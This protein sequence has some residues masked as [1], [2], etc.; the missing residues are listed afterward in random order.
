MVLETMPTSGSRLARDG[1]ITRLF[2][3]E[4]RQP[5]PVARARP[6]R[7]GSL[8]RHIPRFVVSLP[9][10]SDRSAPDLDGDSAQEP[11]GALRID[12]GGGVGAGLP[13]ALLRRPERWRCAGAVAVQVRERRSRVGD[14]S[15]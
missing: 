2:Y 12:S 8:S 7:P 1:T 9:S 10:R 5:D 15:E 6:R 13:R 3:G 11:D 4:L 14:D